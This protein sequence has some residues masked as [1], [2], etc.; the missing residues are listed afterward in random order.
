[1]SNQCQV[2]YLQVV[3]SNRSQVSNLQVVVWYERQT[4]QRG[5]DFKVIG[6][7]GFAGRLALVNAGRILG[8]RKQWD[9]HNKYILYIL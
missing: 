6:D 1:M 2:S 4:W 8:G 3:M 5:Q 7:T 9:Y